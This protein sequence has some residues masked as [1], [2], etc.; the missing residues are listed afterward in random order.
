MPRLWASWRVTSVL[1][2]P[3]GPENRKAPTGFSGSRRP[4]RAILMADASASMAGSWPKITSFR[5]RSR[6]LSWSRS[7]ADTLFGGNARHPRHDLLD[8]FHID[9]VGAFRFRLQASTR[10][11]FVDHVD[12]L[13]GQ[14]ALVDVA[15]SQLYRRRQCV[16]RVRHAVVFLETRTQALQDLHGLAHAGLDDV[17]LLET[18]RQGMIFLEDAP[19]F[20]EGG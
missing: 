17:D 3:V 15:L 11:G 14:L 9:D 4:E 13:V 8:I 5:S 18:A 16:V 19:V 6:F 2:T 20:L 10:A 7:E 1:P 12:G